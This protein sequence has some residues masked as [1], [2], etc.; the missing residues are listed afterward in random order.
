MVISIGG[1]HKV[2]SDRD[3]DIG[4]AVLQP[5][6]VRRDNALP[7]PMHV[8]D[9]DDW[10]GEFHDFYFNLRRFGRGRTNL[11]VGHFD[12][13]FGLEPQTDTHFT[14]Y[15]VL[16][17]QNLGMKKDWGVS[18]N[19]QL[20]KFDYEISVTRGSGVELDRFHDGEM[21]MM[22]SAG[23]NWAVAGRIGTPQERDL[24]AGLSAFYG[25]VWMPPMDITIRR[26]NRMCCDP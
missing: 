5:Y 20:P 11:K 17:M 9:D 21:T 10:E 14:L 4:T 16:P 18:L 6:L 2:F 26:M 8:E 3:G 13:P 7:I 23:R 25:N 24:S 15:Q 19:G 12:V 1:I 22:R